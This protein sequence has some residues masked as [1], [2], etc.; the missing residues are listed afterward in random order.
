MVVR[1]VQSE[2]PTQCFQRLQWMS[3]DSRLTVIGRRVYS[4]NIFS[5][6]IAATPLHHPSDVERH[7]NT[8]PQRHAVR[9]TKDHAHGFIIVL[10]RSPRTPRTQTGLVPNQ[11]RATETLAITA[12]SFALASDRQGSPLRSDSRAGSRP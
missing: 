5:V 4:A 12:A 8:S 1:A 9:N 7:S 2:A 3:I 6:A 10:V 11:Q